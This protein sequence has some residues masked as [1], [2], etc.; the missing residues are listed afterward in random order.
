MPGGSNGGM[1]R[2]AMRSTIPARRTPRSGRPS[3]A[4]SAKSCDWAVATKMRR[5]QAAPAGADPSSQVETP[6]L[7]KSPYVTSR[8]ISWIEY[9]ALASGRRVERDDAPER[10]ADVHRAVDDERR[11][12]ERRSASSSRTA[13]PSRRCDRSTPARAGRRSRA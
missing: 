6:R 8:R 11:R 1:R 12:L 5:R 4:S 10:R 13:A 2:P 7:A 3:R 9:P